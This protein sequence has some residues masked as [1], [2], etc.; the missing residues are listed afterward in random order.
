[1]KL[2]VPE[3]LVELPLQVNY[4]IDWYLILLAAEERLTDQ[5]VCLPEVFFTRL[6]CPRID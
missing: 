2:V 5:K 3:V 6:D 4:F 1:M